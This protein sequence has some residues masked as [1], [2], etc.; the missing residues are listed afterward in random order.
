[1]IISRISQSSFLNRLL[2]PIN[3]EDR[4]RPAAEAGGVWRGW[5]RARGSGESLVGRASKPRVVA[6]SRLTLVA[7]VP[8]RTGRFAGDFAPDLCSV[9]HVWKVWSSWEPILPRSRR[10]IERDPFDASAQGR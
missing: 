1:M 8:V 6:R 4:A 5:G 9:V 7:L 3:W 2:G 10:S